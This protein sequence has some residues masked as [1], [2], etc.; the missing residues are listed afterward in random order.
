M[1]GA[2]R[3]ALWSVS[4]AL[5]IVLEPTERAVLEATGAHHG[6]AAMRRIRAQVISTAADG[7]FAGVIRRNVGV[8]PRPRRHQRLVNC[9]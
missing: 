2:G 8:A 1:A 9:A 4:L 7:G 3:L 5:A 6:H